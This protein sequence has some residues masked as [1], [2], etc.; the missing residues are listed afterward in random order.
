M[1]EAGTERIEIADEE[2]T[3][4]DGGESMLRA[5]HILKKDIQYTLINPSIPF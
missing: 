2:G 3:S 5:G 1:G 4:A